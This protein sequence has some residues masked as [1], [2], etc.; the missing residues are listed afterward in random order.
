MRRSRQQFDSCAWQFSGLRRLSERQNA[1]ALRQVKVGTWLVSKSVPTPRM[2]N[3]TWLDCIDD[4][5]MIRRKW[6]SHSHSF[7]RVVD[8]VRGVEASSRTNIF[9]SPRDFSTEH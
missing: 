4:R 2:S 8:Y 1:F 9:S 6:V 5:W 3:L 7:S